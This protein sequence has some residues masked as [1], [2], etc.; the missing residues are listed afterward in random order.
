MLEYLKLR[1]VGP[2]PEMEMRLAKR[3]N[4]ITG[5]NGLGKTFLLDAAWWA[6]TRKWPR[7]LNPRLT[8]GYKALPTDPKRTATIE[9][10]L[11]LKVKSVAY[12]STWKPRDEAWVGNAGRPWNP[13]LV[14][15]AHADGGFSVWDP[16]RN[17]WKKKGNIDI[18][19]RL[20]G[21]VFSNE[22]V[23]QGLYA[24]IDGK[25][26]KVCNGLLDDWSVWIKENGSNAQLMR[27]ILHDLLPKGEFLGMGPLARLSVNESQD[28]PTIRTGYRQSV[29]I[30]HASSGVRR[31]AGLAYMT[32]WSWNEHRIAAKLL[33]EKP[34]A[35]VIF[36]FDE[37]ESHLHPRWQR[38]ILRALLD[39]TKALHAQAKVQLIIATHSPLILAS[40]EPWFDSDTDS[41]FDLDCNDEKVALTKRAYIRRGEVSNWLTSEAFDLKSARSVE[42]ENAIE[43]AL[44]LLRKSNPSR[45]S[46]KEADAALRAAGLPDI[47]PFW[48]RWGKFVEDSTAGSRRKR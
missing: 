17:Y 19:E 35:Q 33:G 32:M 43:R 48:I 37:L 10:Q 34:T 47:D 29:P 26:T 4:I 5:D 39:V 23:W 21:F 7:E 3:L 27:A 24:N 8:F 36:L 20:P 31:I 1:N 46:I 22:E 25:P 2:A 13:G 15:Y 12:K 18:Q 6:L 42:A 11:T 9:F 44:F 14:I 45:E 40:A 38:L 16:A 28:I 30:V 41:W